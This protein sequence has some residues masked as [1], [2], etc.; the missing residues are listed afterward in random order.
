[1]IVQKPEEVHILW[2]FLLRASL[3]LVD[4]LLT[5]SWWGGAV[6]AGCSSPLGLRPPDGR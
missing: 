5:W 1:M 3:V 2:G 6:M 4:G